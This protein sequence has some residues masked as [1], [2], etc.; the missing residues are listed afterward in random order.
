MTREEAKELFRNDKNS[1]GCYKAVLTKVDAIFDSLEKEPVK[2][3]V[4]PDVSTR[5]TCHSCNKIHSGEN[6][7]QLFEVC[8]NCF[9][10]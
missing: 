8:K 2:D 4:L 1:Q 9:S 6:D 7:D 5:F 3:V 10:K